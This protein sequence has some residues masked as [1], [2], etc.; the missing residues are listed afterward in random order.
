MAGELSLTLTYQSLLTSTLFDYLESGRF[1]DNIA[2]ATPTLDWLMSGNR[3]KL[4]SGGERVTG[5]VMSELNSTAKSYAGYEALDTTSQEGFT[6]WSLAWKL[7]SVSISINGD[8]M[9]ANMGDAALFDLLNA[10][11]QQAEISLADQLSQGVHSDGTGNDSKD[12]TGLVAMC[13][14][15]PTASTYAGIN[16]ANATWWRNQANASVG[17]AATN[18]VPALRTL[19]NSCV[20]GKGGMSSE[21]DFIVTTQTV[22]E[23]YEALLFPFFRFA[24]TGAAGTNTNQANAGIQGLNYKNAKVVWDA[25]CASGTLYILNSNHCWMVVHRDRNM[26]M[27]EGGFQKPVNQD[28]LVTQVLFKGQMVTNANKKL[29]VAAGIT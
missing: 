11:T 8:E 13:D 20:Q 19:Y 24:G 25:D 9:T 22:H 28:A 23:A 21:P 26:S 15:T 4:S 10:K 7:Y 5:A 6:R 17:A 29:G 1:Y 3:I 14:T 2:D 16:R 18:L 27:A 12:L